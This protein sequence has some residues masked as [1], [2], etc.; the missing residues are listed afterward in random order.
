[1]EVVSSTLNIHKL[2][3]TDTKLLRSNLSE[4]QQGHLF[5]ITNYGRFPFNKNSALKFQKFHVPNGTVHSSSTDP[6][7]P[8]AHLVIVFVRYRRLVLGKQLLCQNGKGHFGPTH[9]NERTGQ[10]D[11]PSKVQV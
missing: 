10:S 5:H 1:M 3:R 6:T 7:Q 8:T 4:R 11:P 2:R 9:R